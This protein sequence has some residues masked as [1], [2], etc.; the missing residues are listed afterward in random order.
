MTTFSR[1]GASASPHIANLNQNNGQNAMKA[2]VGHC[3]KVDQRAGGGTHQSTLP[4]PVDEG[5]LQKGRLLWEHAP[6]WPMHQ[7]WSVKPRL[8]ISRVP[9]SGSFPQALA[10][11]T[12]PVVGVG[13]VLE[14]SMISA[15]DNDPKETIP[16]GH[17][18][19]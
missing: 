5:L 2:G 11:S 3:H 16:D 19:T 7:E 9:Y 14:R 18:G 13:P 8:K 6:W 4:V 15:F 12:H 1:T 10:R 17:V